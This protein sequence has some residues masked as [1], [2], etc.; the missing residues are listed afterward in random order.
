M[1]PPHLPPR[2]FDR[3]LIAWHFA[4]RQ[5]GDDFVTTLALDDL[6]TRLI[7]VTRNFEAALIMAPDARQLPVMGRSASGVFQF[8]RAATVVAS[9]GAPLIDPEALILPRDDYDLIVSVFDLT[10]VNDVVGFLARLR[11]HLRPDGLFMGVAIG[12]QSLTELREAWL[13][14]ESEITGGAFARVAPFIPLADAGQLLQRAGFTLP[15]TDVETH[16]VRYGHP[17]K[18]M[19]ELKALGAQNPLAERP[20]RMVTRRLLATASEAYGAIAMDDDARVRATL[21]LIWVSGWAPHESQQQP[22]RRGS[23]TVSLK[24]VLEKKA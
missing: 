14:A 1:S 16:T 11:R 24:D 12:G 20:E 8:E 9:E 18:L 23:A 10:V 5:G 17:L 3:E 13:T 21:E 4:R 22:A 6:A 7:T 15:V 2:V 19:A